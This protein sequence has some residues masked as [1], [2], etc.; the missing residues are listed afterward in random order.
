MCVHNADLGGK[1]ERLKKKRH[2]ASRAW[3]RDAPKGLQT[4]RQRV[5]EGRGTSVRDVTHCVS[6]SCG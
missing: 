5:R 4:V 3:K 2:I 6:P 1:V